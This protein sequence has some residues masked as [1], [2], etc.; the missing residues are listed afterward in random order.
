[1]DSVDAIIIGAGVGGLTAAAYLAQAGQSVLVIEQDSHVGGT[2]HVFKRN[3]FTFPTGPQSITMPDYIAGSLRDLGVEQ[4]LDFI[5]DHFEVRRGSLDIMISRPLDLIEEQ[6]MDHFPQERKGIHFVIKVLEEVI[7]ALDMLQPSDLIE[8]QPGCITD[9][10]ACKVLEKWGS[11]PARDLF[12]LHLKDQSLKDLLGSQGTSETVMS[13]VL[14]AQMWRFMS[15]VGIWY[16]K[17]GIETIPLLLAERVKAFGGE[18]RHGERVKHITV[19][20]GAATGVELEG[21]T[22]IK[23]PLVISDADYRDTIIKLLPSDAFHDDE[24]EEISR[25]PLTSSA[26]TV[27]LGVRRGLVDLSAFRGDHLMVKLKEGKPVPWEMKKSVPEDFMNDDIWLSW[28][29]RH[30]T[31]LAPPG[32]EA[33]II[34]VESPFEVFAPFSGGGR[35]LHQE[36]YYSFKEGLA[37]ALIAV[38]DENILP[39]LSSAVVVREVATPLTYKYWGHRSEGSV[40]GWSWKSGEQP[41]P[42]AR[43]LTVTKVSGLLMVGLQSIT[44][45]FYGGMGTSMYSGKYAS[46]LAL[47]TISTIERPYRKI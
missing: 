23:S 19:Q 28:W 22:I 37:D 34:N 17:G 31:E 20:D 46:D 5:R 42:W 21:G 2:A 32:C 15:S 11:V 40:A 33:L 14:L 44:R 24:L 47:S 27:F 12:D 1:M 41:E 45:L 9:S 38:A 4:Q 43:S 36:R 29:S 35:G 7:T 25:M 3:G 30:D 16:V 8:Q 18:I 10:N 6:L 39:G 26:F 13:I